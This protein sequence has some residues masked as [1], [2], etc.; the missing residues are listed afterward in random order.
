MRHSR[1]SAASMCALP[2]KLSE[3]LMSVEPLEVESLEV[4]WDVL[5]ALRGGCC[6]A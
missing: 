4:C 3:E 5:A 2:A 6:T 1:R